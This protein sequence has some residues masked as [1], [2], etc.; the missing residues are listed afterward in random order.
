MHY[1]ATFV[2]DLLILAD[3]YVQ[4]E[5][6]AS[7]RQRFSEIKHIEEASSYVGYNI[8]Y[9]GD[10]KM[11]VNQEGHA[12]EYIK[13]NNIEA[14]A[15]GTVPCTPEDFKM[16]E[17]DTRPGNAV[18]FASALGALSHLRKTR[19]ELAPILSFLAQHQQNPTKAHNKIIRR[20][21]EYIAQEPELGIIYGDKRTVR[22]TAF[23]DASW[24]SHKL[25]HGHTA[26]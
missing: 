21:W 3:R 14:S 12:K 10:K 6:A 20:A 24:S 11:L 9:L 22:I 26:I 2:D 7:L 5:L 13:T 18:E 25:G 15:K 23:C 16:A 19:P 4:D 1:V 8:K 17:E